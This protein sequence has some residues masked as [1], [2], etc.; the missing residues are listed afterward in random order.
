MPQAMS[1]T[2]VQMCRIA[3]RVRPALDTPQTI[4]RTRLQNGKGRGICVVIAIDWAQ[5]ADPRSV[6]T[7]L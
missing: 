5:L 6:V 4:Q 3:I 2:L 7:L 1:I